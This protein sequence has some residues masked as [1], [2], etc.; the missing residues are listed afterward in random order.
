M[1]VLN[2]NPKQHWVNKVIH[3]VWGS[4]LRPPCPHTYY[5]LGSCL[6]NHPVV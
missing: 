5:S 6:K 3:I 4:H 1:V 2:E